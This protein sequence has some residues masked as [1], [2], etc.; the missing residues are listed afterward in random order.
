[1]PPPTCL[2]RAIQ[3]KTDIIHDTINTAVNVDVRF[4][5]TFPPHQAVLGKIC[6]NKK[7]R[8][9]QM[10]IYMQIMDAQTDRHRTRL[11]CSKRNALGPGICRSKWFWPRS[12]PVL[13]TCHQGGAWLSSAW[14]AGMEGA[15]HP[16]RRTEASFAPPSNLLTVQ[17]WCTTPG[18]THADNPHHPCHQNRCNAPPRPHHHLLARD[19]RGGE[20]QLI[21]AAAPAP[22]RQPAE[23]GRG[24]AQGKVV[25]HRP[26]H[27]VRAGVV[28]GRRSLFAATCPMDRGI[29]SHSHVPHPG[30]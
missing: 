8:W 16:P 14:Q 4:G 24:E 1:M 10:G 11:P 12:P 19:G 6:C 18:C 9:E 26:W 17:R 28:P 2:G 22:L 25:R 5:P 20:R 23:G 27:V 15:R 21:A 13:V 29:P 7:N 30:F 3:V